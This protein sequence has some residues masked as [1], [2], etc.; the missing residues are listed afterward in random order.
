MFIIDTRTVGVR[1]T[2]DIVAYP[3]TVPKKWTLGQTWN[4]YQIVGNKQLFSTEKVKQLTGT[5][6]VC[7]E[8]SPIDEEEPTLIH[9]SV[10]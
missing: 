10:Y 3:Y 1:R 2:F 7:Q 9:P 8:L 4:K 5:V 6:M